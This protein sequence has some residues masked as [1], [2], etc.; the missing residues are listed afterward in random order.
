M[1]ET[2]RRR[3]ESAFRLAR[4]A[5]GNAN[6][7]ENALNLGLAICERHGLDLDGFDIPGRERGRP[8]RPSDHVRR[9]EPFVWSDAEAFEQYAAQFRDLAGKG[10]EAARAERERAAAEDRRNA[11]LAANALF[12]AGFYAYRAEDADDGSR[13][14]QVFCGQL[15]FDDVDDARIRAIAVE[16]APAFYSEALEKAARL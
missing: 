6:E 15:D 1:S 12:A 10:G 14:W 11:E 16:R 7:R 4:D 9:E 5:R 13:R 2:A 8:D 3:A